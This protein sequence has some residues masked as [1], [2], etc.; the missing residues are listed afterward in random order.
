MRAGK[1]TA[2]PLF[3]RVLSA[4]LSRDAEICPMCA[5][6]IVVRGTVAGDR[7]GVC[8]TCYAR[9]LRDAALEAERE[10]TARK[11]YDASKHRLFRERK[12]KGGWESREGQTKGTTK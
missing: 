3:E 1:Q 11:E 6:S 8:P 4:E 12:R 5:C 2:K 10:E 9:A 7:Y